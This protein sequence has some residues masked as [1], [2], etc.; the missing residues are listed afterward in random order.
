MALRSRHHIHVDAAGDEHPPHFRPGSNLK[1]DDIALFSY[2]SMISRKARV[3]RRK[4]ASH[5]SDHA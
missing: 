2:L 1:R 3:C 5:F 4:T